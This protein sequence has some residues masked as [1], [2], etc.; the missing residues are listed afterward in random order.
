LL[1]FCDAFGHSGFASITPEWSLSDL[2]QL[3]F[4]RLEISLTAVA[5]LATPKK[6]KNY[7]CVFY[8]K[9]VKKIINKYIKKSMKKYIHK[10]FI[11]KLKKN[12]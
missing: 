9:L 8:L 12:I 5:I 4:L 10:K 2:I 6:L 11:K 3:F 7:V 1:I